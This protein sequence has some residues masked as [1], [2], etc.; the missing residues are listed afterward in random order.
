[1]IARQGFLEEGLH[2]MPKPFSMKSLA[3]KIRETLGT[4]T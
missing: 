2:F 1:V 3:A 4:I